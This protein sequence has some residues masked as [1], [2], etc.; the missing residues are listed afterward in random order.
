MP[1]TMNHSTTRSGIEEKASS[2][3]TTKRKEVLLISSPARKR[4]Q[5]SKGTLSPR[6]SQNSSNSGLLS[7]AIHKCKIEVTLCCSHCENSAC[8]LEAMTE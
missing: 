7:T 4:G 3:V 6:K 2:A 5:P 1:L 8:K